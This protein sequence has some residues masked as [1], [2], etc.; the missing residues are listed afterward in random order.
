MT[1][2][3]PQGNNSCLEVSVSKLGGPFH[4]FGHIAIRFEVNPA[5]RGDLWNPLKNKLPSLLNGAQ[6]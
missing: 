2:T 3:W 1:T 5:F 4:S 6:D